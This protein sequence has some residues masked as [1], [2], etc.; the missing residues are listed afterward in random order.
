MGNRTI[1]AFSH[2]EAGKIEQDPEGFIRAI[3]HML[4]S[5]VSDL[6]DEHDRLHQRNLKHYGV[7]TSPTHHNSSKAE[8][9]LSSENGG[10]E[11]HRQRF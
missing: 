6:P 8:V 2:D 7:T 4:N 5:G 1:V 11:Y 9:V 10:H 3:M